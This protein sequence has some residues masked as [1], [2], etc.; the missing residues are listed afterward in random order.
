MIGM[1]AGS[2]MGGNV[3]PTKLRLAVGVVLL[4]VSPLVFYDAFWG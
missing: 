1:F 2:R 3:D 4:L